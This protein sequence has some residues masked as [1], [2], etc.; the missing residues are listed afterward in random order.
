MSSKQREA[1]E[2]IAE[3]VNRALSILNEIPDSCSH[4][5]L[6][7]DVADVLCL[8]KETYIPEALAAP[9]RECDRFADDLQADDLHEAF[10]K[11]CNDCDCPMG[12]VYRMEM[13]GL[14]DVRCASI[15]K[16]FARFALSEATKEEGVK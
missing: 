5:G 13:K 6:V 3:T 9:P 11:H 8:I 7:E 16:C 10:V 14:L 2:K 4:N 15:L 12:C 1:L